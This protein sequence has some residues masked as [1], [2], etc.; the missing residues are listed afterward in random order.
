MRALLCGLLLLC[1]FTAFSQEFGN[2]VYGKKD[3][4]DLTL[5]RNN[6]ATFLNDSVM[7]LEVRALINVK[8]DSYVAMFGVSQTAETIDACN[9]LINNRING[10]LDSLKKLSVNQKDIFIDLITQVPVY[11]FET[12]KKIFSKTTYNEV[13]KGF[14]L[15]KNIHIAY[16]DN[17][18]IN[19]ILSSAVRFEIYDLIKVDYF[20]NNY[21]SV[22]DTLRQESIRLMNK[23]VEDYKKLG[24]KVNPKYQI[25][26]ENIASFY[27]AERYNSYTAFSGSNLYLT[28]KTLSN[29]RINMSQKQTTYFY[30]KF[31]YNEFDLV[32]NPIILEPVVQFI[33]DLKLRYSLKRM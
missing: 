20:I 22:Y 33:F 28:D 26:S 12:E 15:T 5:L 4:N 3:N 19:Q 14:S 24:I 10:F 18:I 17:K 1:F 23:K 31:P 21:S 6:E 7:V 32:I 29:S 8:A 13:P 16:K 25:V 27:P 30:N 9:R 2:I 11:E